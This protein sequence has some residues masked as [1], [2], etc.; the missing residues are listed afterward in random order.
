MNKMVESFFR[1]ASFKV[2]KEGENYY[3]FKDQKT[4]NELKVEVISD[5]KINIQYKDHFDE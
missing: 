2:L 5:N 3:I 4:L 1:D